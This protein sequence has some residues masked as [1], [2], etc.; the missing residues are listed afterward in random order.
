MSVACS[1][2]GLRRKPYF[3]QFVGNELDFVASSKESH[4]N[5]DAKT[6]IAPDSLY[7]LYG[8]WA[9]RYM[10]NP[11]GARQILDFLLPG[12]L[13]GQETLLKY[14]PNHALQTLTPVSLC[15]LRASTFDQ[16]VRRY[17]DL[18]THILCNLLDDRRR[19]DNR[20]VAIGKSNGAQR[21]AYLMSELYERQRQRGMANETDRWCN[22][23]L[24]RQHIADALGMSG[25]HVN[26]ALIDLRSASLATLASNMLAVDDWERLAAFGRYSWFRHEM[27]RAII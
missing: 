18:T 2:C 17:P 4:I 26:R 23:P 13:I 5:L 14:K 11:D 1:D 8:G 6:E 12:D 15:A 3:R 7:T 24:R 22:F 25:T 19:L 16:I 27:P 20:L 21:V 9:F 10:R